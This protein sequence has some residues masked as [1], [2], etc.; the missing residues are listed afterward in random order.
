VPDFG[1]NRSEGAIGVSAEQARNHAGEVQL[2]KTEEGRGGNAKTRQG[3]DG[4]SLS[5]FGAERNQRLSFTK[6]EGTAGTTKTYKNEGDLHSGTN[7]RQKRAGKNSKKVRK[8]RCLY[9]KPQWRAISR[10]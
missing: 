6:V 1:L 10:S 4:P 8:D 7:D 9:E 2:K 5:D 3:S